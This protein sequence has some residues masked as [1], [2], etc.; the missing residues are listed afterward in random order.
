MSVMRSRIIPCLLAGLASGISSAHGAAGA[1]A[2]DRPDFVESSNVVGSGRLQVE[3]SVLFERDRDGVGRT[4]TWSTPTLLRIGA[5]DSVEL[6]IE[7]DGRAVTEYSGAGQVRSTR[8]G[9]SDASF[10]VKWHVTDGAGAQPSLGILL[11]ADLDSGS[12]FLRGQGVRPSARIVGEWELPG[13]VSLGLMPGMGIERNDG[14]TRY[15]YGILGLVVG[16]E[17]G[18][19]VRGFVEL[20][21]PR[22]ARVRD[23]GSQASLDLGAAWL[24][25]DTLQ[26][27]A[28]LAHGLNRRTPD[29]AFTLGLSFKR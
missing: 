25:S 16:S 13:N 8:S 3:T 9:W 1:I 7:T 22:I 4:R 6:R 27:D 5:G 20:A 15:R 29:L 12:T 14:G 17:L 2:T 11:H 18:Q 19:G 21:M 28:M 26:L 10:G 24:L 23:G